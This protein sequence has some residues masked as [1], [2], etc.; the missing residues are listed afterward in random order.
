MKTIVKS[1][2]VL[3]AL[4]TCALTAGAQPA[5]GPPPGDGMR[6]HRPPPILL[7]VLDADKDGTISATEIDNASTVLLTLDKNSDG[8]LTMDELMPARP[9]GTNNV[10]PP[11]M[12]GRGGHR[13]PPS[14]VLGVLDADHDGVISASEIANASTALKTLDKD[15]DGQL[16]SDELRPSRS[17]CPDG[18]RPPEGN[19]PPPDME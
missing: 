8:Q 2:L 6:G 16:S 1:T 14:P 3:L 12:K 5:G 11:S 4:G 9:E 10:A 18:N 19:G 7:T 17:E 15:G 13:P